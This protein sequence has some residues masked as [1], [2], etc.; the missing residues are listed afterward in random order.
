ME[1][2]SG[3]S[4]G[5]GGDAVRPYLGPYLEKLLSDPFAR[6]FVSITPSTAASWPQGTVI[7][8]RAEKADA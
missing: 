5:E 7:S 1:G 4:T 2:R 8:V 6:V 3:I